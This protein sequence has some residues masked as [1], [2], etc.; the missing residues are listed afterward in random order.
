MVLGFMSEFKVRQLETQGRLRSVRGV[1]G[2]AWYP[3]ADVLALRGVLARPDGPRGGK[4]AR[5]SAPLAPS[6]GGRWSDAALIAHLRGSRVGQTEPP[7]PRTVVDLVVD[8]GISIARAE[9]VYRFWLAHD[10]HPLAE[11][12]RAA[13]S[14]SAGTTARQFTVP[15]DPKVVGPSEPAAPD[16]A[17]AERRGQERLRRDTLIQQLRHPNPTAR[18]AAF[19]GLKG[20]QTE[21]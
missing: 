7:R 11:A 12:V 17:P 8:T 18:A 6:T 16:A 20:K 15:S 19:L 10:D 4:A 21:S 2:S 14:R 1:M 5:P 13:R 3:R 9:S